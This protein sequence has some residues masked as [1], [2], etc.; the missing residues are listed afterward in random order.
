MM[1]RDDG[2][3]SVEIKCVWDRTVEHYMAFEGNTNRIET[4]V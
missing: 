1:E 4:I 3:I 2:G